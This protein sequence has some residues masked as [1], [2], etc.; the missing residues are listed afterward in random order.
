MAENESLDLG[1][2]L[3]WRS[4]CDAVCRGD[5]AEDVARAAVVSTVR[6][7]RKVQEQVP[8]A[9]LFNIA[10]VAPERLPTFAR[11][12]GGHDYIKLLHEVAQPPLYGGGMHFAFVAAIV[13]KFWDQIILRA[14]PSRRWPSLQSCIAFLTVVRANMEPGLRSVA[15]GLAQDPACRPKVPAGYAKSTPAERTRSMLPQSL[16]RMR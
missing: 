14:V 4:V 6:T 7:I 15:A 2:S 1:K 12:H 16:M 10:S 5:S 11:A 9:D 8:F 13:E 3:R